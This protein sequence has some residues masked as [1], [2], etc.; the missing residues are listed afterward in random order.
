VDKDNVVPRGQE[1]ERYYRGLQVSKGYFN[2]PEETKEAFQSDGW[3][4]TGDA[5]YID[6]DG[7]LHF[8]DRKKDLIIASGYN[9]A[10][11][12]IEYTIIR[13]PAVLEV[14]V[15][16]VPDKDIINFCK[17]NIA[18]HK[19]PRMVEFINELPK[20][21]LGKTLRRVLRDRELQKG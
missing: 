2:K 6:E 15:V 5:G 20:N 13:H 21:L 11:V 3:L 10:P 16:G 7:F 8:T 17:E 9:I 14:A 12:E 18:T 1:G 4:R 19:V